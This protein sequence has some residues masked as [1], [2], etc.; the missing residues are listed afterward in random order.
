MV[1][2]GMGEHDMV[3]PGD[4]LGGKEFGQGAGGRLGGAAV[5]KGVLSSG[6]FDIDGVTLAYIKEIYAEAR[7]YGEKRGVLRGRGEGYLYRGG[8]VV[9]LVEGLRLKG[10]G[11]KMEYG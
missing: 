9:E 10:G 3:Y 5:D 11:G 6:Q 7:G 8:G 1:A 2:V 4:F